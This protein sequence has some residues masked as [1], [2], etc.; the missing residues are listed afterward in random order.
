[1]P[2][3]QRI[4]LLAVFISIAVGAVFGLLPRNWI[5]Q[6]SGLDPDGGSGLLESLIS[7]LIAIAV[8][9]AILVSWPRRRVRSSVDPYLASS[10]R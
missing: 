4:Y 10:L 8:G 9:I 7:A 3:R 5:E 2:R 1:M 6:C